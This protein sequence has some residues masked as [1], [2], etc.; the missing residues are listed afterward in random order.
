[1]VV[2]YWGYFVAKLVAAGLLMR[3]LW[4]FIR[5]LFPRR[6]YLDWQQ[7]PFAHDLGYTSAM[8]LFFLMS[9]GLVYSTLR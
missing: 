2:K 4:S 1:M 8:M 6:V 5:W 7:S 9:A 3:I